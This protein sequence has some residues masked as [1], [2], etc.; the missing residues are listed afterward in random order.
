VRRW[1]APKAESPLVCQD[2]GRNSNRNADRLPWMVAANQRFQAGAVG[3]P[4]RSLGNHTLRL[5]PVV[6]CRPFPRP[7]QRFS[8][9]GSPR[10]K[11]M[12]QHWGLCFSKMAPLPT[13][14]ALPSPVFAGRSV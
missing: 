5:R 9:M 12:K 7:A 8:S 1:L 2:P 3:A 13:L 4:K 11:N 10:V 6:N 14:R